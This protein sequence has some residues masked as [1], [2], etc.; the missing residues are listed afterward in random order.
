MGMD[1]ARETPSGIPA[2]AESREPAQVEE[3]SDLEK[4][5]NELLEDWEGEADRWAGVGM[6]DADAVLTEEPCQN[7]PPEGRKARVACDRKKMGAPTR[8]QRA[9]TS[10]GGES[11][12]R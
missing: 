1:D 6:D 2:N 12:R 3:A 4:E 5:R 7:S 8:P 11:N 10:A 9:P